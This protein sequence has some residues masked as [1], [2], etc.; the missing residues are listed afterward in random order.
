MNEGMDSG[1]KCS[2]PLKFGEPWSVPPIVS[3]EYEPRKLESFKIR[4]VFLVR[5]TFLGGRACSSSSLSSVS[6]GTGTTAA[7][8]LDVVPVE[9][10]AD[11]LR[12][13]FKGK[14]H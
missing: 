8:R 7:L 11:A 4:T 12:F 2:V 9:G 14:A 5:P 10:C 6:V 1:K 3:R 13:F